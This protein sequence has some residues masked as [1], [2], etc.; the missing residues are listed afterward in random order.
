MHEP[1]KNIVIDSCKN[2]AFHGIVYSIRHVVKFDLT[3]SFDN[4]TRPALICIFAIASW[5]TIK[6]FFSLYSI[7]LTF[8]L[9][10][11]LFNLIYFCLW[12][13]IIIINIY[14]QLNVLRGT[15]T[16]AVRLGADV[17]NKGSKTVGYWLLGCS[18]MVM[19]AV[20]LGITIYFIMFFSIC[21]VLKEVI[22]KTV[23]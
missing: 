5:I 4:F 16:T 21:I 22:K 6:I 3:A 18:G 15:T 20:V 14:F 9:I 12:I 11:D 17:S 1:R 13:K 7:H 8:V 23:K 2:C 19:V 10:Y